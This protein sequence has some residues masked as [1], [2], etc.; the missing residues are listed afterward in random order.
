MNDSKK[1]RFLKNCGPCNAALQSRLLDRF[2]HAWR[3]ES[4]CTMSIHASGRQLLE[5]SNLEDPA[6]EGIRDIR[7]ELSEAFLLRNIEVASGNRVPIPDERDMDFVYRIV[8]AIAEIIERREPQDS[9]E[10]FLSKC[11]PCNRALQTHLR[12]HFRSD[13]CWGPQWSMTVRVPGR[14]LVRIWHTQAEG[15]ERMDQIDGG[16]LA[17]LKEHDIPVAEPGRVDFP[18]DEDIDFVAGLLSAFEKELATQPTDNFERYLANSSPCNEALAIRLHEEFPRFCCWGPSKSM[19]INE[20]VDHVRTTAKRR[21]CR[22]YNRAGREP[23]ET[24]RICQIRSDLAAKLREEGM[25]VEKGFVRMIE[26]NFVY[27]PETVD[28]HFIQSFVTTLHSLLNELGY[29]V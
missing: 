22:I 7:Y 21:L 28:E 13:C 4:D 11:G 3:P 24:E 15:G 25:N 10:R 5:I 9:Y 6:G 8:A 17:T 1:D 2:P 16:F 12:G 20:P 27:F 23:H 14:K 19:T 26:D 29:E 18:D